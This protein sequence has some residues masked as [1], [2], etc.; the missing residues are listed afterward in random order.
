VDLTLREGIAYIKNTRPSIIAGKL[1]NAVILKNIPGKGFALFYG[2]DNKN[3]LKAFDIA[4]KELW[5]KSVPET[6]SFSMLTT[7]ADIYLLTKRRDQMVEGGYAIQGYSA[8]DGTNYPR[9]D[10]KDRKGSQLKV[11]SFENDPVTARPVLSGTIIN[12]NW[13]NTASV[14]G[15]H[16]GACDGVFTITLNGPKKSDIKERFSYWQDGSKYPDIKKNGMI[17]EGS[18]YPRYATSI[19]DYNGNTYFVGSS[20]LRKT[21]V[22]GIIASV[23]TL[24][25]FVPPLLFMSGGTH[26]A[27]Q[28]D[29]VV[30]KQDSTGKVRFDNTI[31]ASGSRFLPSKVDFA[32]FG[33]RGF[34]EVAN[35]AN[36]SNFLI[37][38]EPKAATIY[39]VQNRKVVRKVPHRDGNVSTYIFPAKEGHIMVMEYNRKAKET[40]LSIEALQ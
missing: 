32:Y 17:S 34:Y 3:T 7:N 40:K 13:G 4:G 16:K 25:F 31:D 1:K 22:G 6:T 37:V 27:K 12:T 39:N 11:L 35:A 36:K 20:Y 28:T 8:A 33:G 18:L 15:L 10:L 29:V 19:R 14:K 26:K 21:R 23:I 2:D 30:L 5:H 38:D 24:P 9:Y